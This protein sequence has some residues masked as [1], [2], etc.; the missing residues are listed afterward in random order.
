M[1]FWQSLAND[2]FFREDVFSLNTDVD[3]GL[4]YSLRI[5]QLIEFFLCVSEQKAKQFLDTEF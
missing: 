4:N 1:W 3:S 2:F 5:W